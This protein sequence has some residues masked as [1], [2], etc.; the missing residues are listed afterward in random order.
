MATPT[1]YS[2]KPDAQA[3]AI[4]VSQVWAQANNELPTGFTQLVPLAWNGGYLLLAATAAGKVSICHSA[5]SRRSS[6][7]C[8]SSS[9][10]VRLWTS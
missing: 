4:D 6:H 1:I 10:W 2:I 5:T 3:G 8:R 7:R 9:I